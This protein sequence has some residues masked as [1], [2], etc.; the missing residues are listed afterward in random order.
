MVAKRRAI[1]QGSNNRDGRGEYIEIHT[2]RQAVQGLEGHKFSS[3]PCIFRAVAGRLFS[4]DE[5]LRLLAVERTR[6]S[7][8]Q[9]AAYR[10]D[11]LSFFNPQS[12]G[13]TITNQT[14]MD[15]RRMIAHFHSTHLEV[16]VGACV[17]VQVWPSSTAERWRKIPGMLTTSFPNHTCFHSTPAVR[18]VREQERRFRFI[19]ILL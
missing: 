19:V 18:C 13:P 16:K 17:L 8:E 1:G 6:V 4:W 7:R 2:E 11:V 9:H 12:V 15:A 10:F 5:R 14:T 3:P